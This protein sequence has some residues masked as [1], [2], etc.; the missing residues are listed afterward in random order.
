MVV[1]DLHAILLTEPCIG[2]GEL[3]FRGDVGENRENKLVREFKNYEDGI[4]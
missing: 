2:T 3:R 1:V 4:R